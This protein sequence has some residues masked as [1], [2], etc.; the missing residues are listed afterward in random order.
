MES[1]PTALEVSETVRHLA[2]IERRAAELRWAYRQVEA[3]VVLAIVECGLSW[4]EVARVAYDEPPNRRGTDYAR[5]AFGDSVALYRDAG[6]LPTD[7]LGPGVSQMF[8]ANRH[9][10]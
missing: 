7:E 10:A 2:A 1:T 9:S 3:A 5:R 8:R 6:I 4:Q